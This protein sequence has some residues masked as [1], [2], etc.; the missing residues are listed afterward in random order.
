MVATMGYTTLAQVGAD[1]FQQAYHRARWQRRW[2]RLI[3]RHLTL[4]AF[5][6]AKAAVRVTGMSEQGRQEIPLTAIVGSVGRAQD[7]TVGFLPLNERLRVRWLRVY[8]AIDTMQHLPPV[9]LYQLGKRYFVSDGNHRVSVSKWLD[10]P[11]ITAEVIAVRCQ[12]PAS[13]NQRRAFFADWR[14][15]GQNQQDARN[16]AIFQRGTVWSS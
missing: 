13:V 6:E 5:A 7:F 9:A 4:P 8:D 12:A 1:P 2:A 14:K 11:A 10:L 3:G 16:K 15:Q